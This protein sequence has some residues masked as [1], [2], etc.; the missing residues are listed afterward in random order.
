VTD[1][2]QK[3]G[4]WVDE[5]PFRASGDPKGNDLFAQTGKN[6]VSPSKVI[7]FVRRVLWILYHGRQESA[8]E[9]S[10][11]QPMGG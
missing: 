10:A 11:D 3:P 8:M 2:D 5:T 7:L 1:R 9:E 4:F 6:L